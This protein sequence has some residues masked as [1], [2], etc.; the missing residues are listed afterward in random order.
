MSTST[1]PNV[2]SSPS[3]LLFG[4]RDDSAAAS[5]GARATHSSPKDHLPKAAA[6]EGGVAQPQIMVPI[7]PLDN[8]MA[9]DNLTSDIKVY[10]ES[11]NRCGKRNSISTMLP[12]AALSDSPTRQPSNCPESRLIK[13]VSNVSEPSEIAYM[14]HL[15]LGVMDK[16]FSSPQLCGG[17]L[18]R[19]P[20]VLMVLPSATA[21]TPRRWSSIVGSS[22]TMESSLVAASGQPAPFALKPCHANATSLASK[23]AISAEPVAAAKRF[24]RKEW[25]PIMSSL[26]TNLLPGSS[27][28]QMNKFKSSLDVNV[29]LNCSNSNSSSNL[30]IYSLGPARSMSLGSKLSQPRSQNRKPLSSDLQNMAKLVQLC[31]RGRPLVEAL[32]QLRA[33]RESIDRGVL[34]ERGLS[35]RLARTTSGGQQQQQVIVQGLQRH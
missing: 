23:D 7:Q 32:A 33:F 3:A 13:D 9:M 5:H 14:E 17:S 19:D 16:C 6:V 25:N 31:T 10:V 15:H 29:K 28:S 18:E 20:M 1:T 24:L 11:L 26:P 27:F 35:S 30:A 12:A 22:S 8:F 21:T 34:P 2:L 4:G